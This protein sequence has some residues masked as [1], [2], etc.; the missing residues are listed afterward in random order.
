MPTVHLFCAFIGFGKTTLAKRIE[1]DTGAL[2]ITPDDIIK[3]M[4]GNDVS[5]DFMDRAA[6]A[7]QYAWEQI[8]TA[9][10]AGRDVI[11]D[12]GYWTPAAR[13]YATEKV[14]SL[15]GRP[16]WHQ[17]QCDISVAKMRA[18]NRSKSDNEL[19]ID[20]KF[21]DDNLAQYSPIGPDEGL[22]VIVHKN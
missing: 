8:A 12:A 4:F 21:F 18:L 15:G 20:E 5:D 6:R 16:V 10:R 13:Q 2:R 14:K 19:S 7:E 3:D 22:D 17:I 9:I 1:R 11:Y